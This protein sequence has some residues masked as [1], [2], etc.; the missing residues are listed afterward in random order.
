MSRRLAGNRPSSTQL[1]S[2]SLRTGLNPTAKLFQRLRQR[3]TQSPQPL[4]EDSIPLRVLVQGLVTVGIIATDVAAADSIDFQGISL[5]AV[6]LS[7]VGAAWSGYRRRNRNIPVKFCIAI[8]MLL[9]L[10]FFFVRLWTERNDTRLALATLLIHL[11]VLHSFDLPRRKDLGYSAVIGLILLGVAATLSQTLAFA[12]LLLLFL[13]IALPALVLDYRSRLGLAS[14]SV[15]NGSFDLSPK[16]LGAVLLSVVGLGLAIFM[17][18]PRMP[19]YQLRSFPVSS[20]IQVGEQFNSSTIVNPGYVQEGK[21][22]T[23]TGTG[24]EQT[25]AGKVDDEFYYGFNS[26]INQNLRG[27]MKPKVVMRVR[28]QSPGFWRVLAFDRYT[29]QGWEIS[30]NAEDQIQTLQRPDWS[31]RFYLPDAVTL[32]K[33]REVIQSYTI[34]ANLPNLIPALFE[35][36]EL[37]FPTQKAAID[38]EGGLRSPVP[39]SEG[40]TYTV[41]SN[42]PYRDRT[43]LR[44]SSTAYPPYIRDYYLSSENILPRIRQKTEE[45]IATSPKALTTPSETALYLAQALKQRYRLRQD[46]PFFSPD[47]DLVEAFLFKYEGGYPDHFATALTVMLRSIGIPA[48][49][50][51]GFA[52]GEFNPFTGY[53]QVKNTDA[54]ALAEVYFHKYGWFAFDAIPGHDLIPPSIEESQTFGVL[55]QFW[56]WVASWLPSP[57]TG[58]FNQIFEL[59]GRAI[60][61]L[62]SLFT[63]GWVG[64]LTGLGILTGIS[65]LS[66]LTWSGW[67]TWRYR[68]WLAKL[69]PMESLYQ[70]MLHKLATQGFRKPPYLTP[71]EYAQEHSDRHPPELARAIAEIS[72]AYVTWRY[73]GVSPNIPHLKQ[74]LKKM[75]FKL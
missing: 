45:L 60:A 70:Q 29:G 67:Q 24:N 32:N 35:A 5:W 27:V 69:P 65:F 22:G 14:P 48:R 61:T 43:L 75:R 33:T 18:L 63:Q 15:K 11:Q 1:S 51:M 56:S 49:L 9:A 26:K 57:L 16:R 42:V 34:V 4:P 31:F 10:A 74:R 71:L 53:Y 73:S 8:A 3:L 25:G 47:E 39:L 66:W 36:K 40:L 62:L 52:P 37:Y 13:A 41:V 72:Q 55:K 2:A 28:S 19:G 12:P 38:A 54:Y 30:R 21:Q 44:K 50:V 64:I 46:L 20:P 17:L 59:L 7:F 23:G 58:A 6:P 68:Y